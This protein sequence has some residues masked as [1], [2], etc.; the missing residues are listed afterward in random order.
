MKLGRFVTLNETQLKKGIAR[1]LR[2]LNRI[3]QTMQIGTTRF[4]LQPGEI[5]R[6]RVELHERVAQMLDHAV[7]D[8][9]T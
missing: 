3:Q 1:W 2:R 7:P 4:Q 8:A 5:R 6:R 9:T